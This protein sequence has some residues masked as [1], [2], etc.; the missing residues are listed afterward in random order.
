MCLRTCGKCKMEKN[1]TDFYKKATGNCKRIC[2]H[3][4]IQQGRKYEIYTCTVC[5]ITMNKKNK[6]K[7]NKSHRHVM[8]Y[9]W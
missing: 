5:E 3:C 9:F 1:E 7:H 6:N 8:N 2:K 4:E